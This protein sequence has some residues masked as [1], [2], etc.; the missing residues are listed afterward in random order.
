MFLFLFF[1]GGVYLE[2]KASFGVELVDDAIGR[3][4]FADL[5]VVDLLLQRV[6][7]HQA[8]DEARLRLPIPAKQ[9]ELSRIYSVLLGST[10]FYR[11]LQGF[12]GFH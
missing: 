12:T 3:A 10:R 8:V 1:V 2:R 6:V 5:A 9:P 4:L 7:R 11:V